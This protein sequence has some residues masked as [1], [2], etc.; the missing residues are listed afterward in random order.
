LFPNDAHNGL[1]YEKFDVEESDNN[2]DNIESEEEES[3]KNF[4]EVYEMMVSLFFYLFSINLTLS[5]FK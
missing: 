1:I 4:Y 2:E 3:E 5:L